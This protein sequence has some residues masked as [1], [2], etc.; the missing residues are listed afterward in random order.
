MIAIIEQGLIIGITGLGVFLTFRILD[1]ADLT[2]EG[3]F[4]L[5]GALTVSL[6]V[7][8]LHPV[9]ALLISMI[10]G[11]IA[12]M[13]TGL[14]FR[15]LKVHVLLA[16]IL[17]MTM[18][19]SINI[20]IM[21]GPN[22]PIPMLTQQTQMSSFEEM[23]GTDPLADL[24]GDLEESAVQEE[25]LPVAEDVQAERALNIFDNARDGSDLMILTGIVGIIICILFIFLKTDLGT[26]L[27]GFGSNPEGVEAFGMSRD[28]ISILGLA[29]ANVL[30]SLSGG[31]FT[32]Y[33]GFADVTMGQGMII[34]GLAMV[35][36]GEI[37]FGKI[38]PLFG[39]IAPI[40]GGVIYQ[41]ILAIV[42]RYGY[43]IGFRASD[44]KLLTAL[45]IVSVIAFS[46]IQNPNKRKKLKGKVKS[47]CSNSKI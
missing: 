43:R 38:K 3:S 6:I 10:C 32:L 21:D 8:G 47:I 5:G 45:F 37:I 29:L 13:I 40:V 26:V 17:V 31:L 28:F 14:I 16:G 7:M 15:K 4:G 9:L 41:A 46:L 18:L 42:M 39:L 44:M 11:G 33:S 20:R 34:T 1:M 25:V 22:L 27:R 23:S 35:M 19:Y 2:V 24:F 30:V 36:V 12:G